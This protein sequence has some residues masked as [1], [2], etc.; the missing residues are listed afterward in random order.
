[1]LQQSNPLSSDLV[2]EV[3]VVI[4]ILLGTRLLLFHLMCVHVFKVKDKH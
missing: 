3:M 4:N 1:M 2:L